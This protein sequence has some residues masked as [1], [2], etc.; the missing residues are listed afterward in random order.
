MK[1]VAST[2]LLKYTKNGSFLLHRWTGKYDSTGFKIFSL[3]FVNESFQVVDQLQVISGSAKTQKRDLCDPKKD[4]SGSGNPCPEGVY[5]IGEIIRMQYPETGVGYTKIPL[6]VLPQF[7][8]NNRS[9]L[10]FHSD[11]NRT[12]AKGSLGCIVTYNERDMD[13]IVNWCLQKAKP[14]TLVVDY[15]M[16]LLKSMGVTIAAA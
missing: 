7:N 15:E 3:Q 2:P 12:T 16:G 9:E 4:Y 10:L 5:R 13:R 1:L 8:V 14:N 11:Y 6:F